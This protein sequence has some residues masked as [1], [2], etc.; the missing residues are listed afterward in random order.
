MPYIFYDKPYVFFDTEKA[1]KITWCRTQSFCAKLF[2]KPH[3]MQEL[4]WSSCDNP[5]KH[6][7]HLCS[8][9]LSLFTKYT[10][11]YIAEIKTHLKPTFLLP[12][13]IIKS[14]SMNR[15]K[16]NLYLIFNYPLTHC[17]LYARERNTY[18]FLH[19]LTSGKHCELS[20]AFSARFFP[21]IRHRK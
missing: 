10:H 20:R 12:K 3:K 17:A 7:K 15:A 1:S 14:T 18:I 9:T 8:I 13:Q 19:S 2:D 6:E 4:R 21:K 16:L 11:F 5:E